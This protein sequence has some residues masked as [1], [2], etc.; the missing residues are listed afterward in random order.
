MKYPFIKVFTK[1]E[2]IQLVN[3]Y[4]DQIQLHNGK[5]YLSINRQWVKKFKYNDKDGF[6]FGASSFY[7]GETKTLEDIYN[8]WTRPML[9]KTIEIEELKED[10]YIYEDG[11]RQELHIDFYIENDPCKYAGCNQNSY[12]T[13]CDIQC[14]EKDE[15]TKTPILVQS[16]IFDYIDPNV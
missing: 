8:Y 7:G 6:I 1:E 11:Y 13:Y 12:G 9:I 14:S 10:H 2:W 5:I 4:K 3:Q 15:Q 16:N